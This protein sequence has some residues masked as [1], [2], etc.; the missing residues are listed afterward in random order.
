MS[1]EF[2]VQLRLPRTISEDDIIEV[3]ARI[4]HP[5]NAGLSLVETAQTPFDRFVRQEGAVFVRTVEIYY[6]DELVSKF[7]MNSSTSNDPLLAFK[8]RANKQALIRVIVTNHAGETVEASQ[9][10]VFT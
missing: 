1:E 3:K 10:V 4:K 7:S 9:D 8:L 5:V 2:E 6:D